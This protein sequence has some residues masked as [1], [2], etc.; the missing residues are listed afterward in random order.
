MIARKPLR[1]GQGLALRFELR[2]S[3]GQSLVR[4]DR[5]A[6]VI[7][8]PNG[9]IYG[10]PLKVVCALGETVLRDSSDSLT[11]KEQVERPSSSSLKIYL[12]C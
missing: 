9:F 12:W 7:A 5:L 11:H 10:S 1:A 4:L 2:S 6:P 8:A 3:W